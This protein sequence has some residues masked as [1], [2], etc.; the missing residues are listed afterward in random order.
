M[1]KIA[2]QVQTYQVLSLCGTAQHVV[3]SYEAVLV[4]ALFLLIQGG[5]LSVGQVCRPANLVSGRI[6]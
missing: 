4:K 5:L 1:S 6:G 2:G 3:P